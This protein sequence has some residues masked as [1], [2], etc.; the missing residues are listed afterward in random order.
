[1]KSS[2]NMPLFTTQTCGLKMF[3]VGGWDRELETELRAHLT[4]YKYL[5]PI[6]EPAIVA[7]LA[8]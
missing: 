8:G 4:M 5:S 3:H 2:E 1:M 6:I 7:G